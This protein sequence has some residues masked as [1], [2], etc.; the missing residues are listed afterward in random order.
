MKYFVEYLLAKLVSRYFGWV[1]GFGTC[2]QAGHVNAGMKKRPLAEEEAL[3]IVQAMAESRDSIG[4]GS[5]A[6]TLSTLKKVKFWNLESKSF[7]LEFLTK[8]CKIIVNYSAP[9]F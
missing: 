4:R 2:L 7:W 3:L 6:T 9:E 1:A 8:F 5:D